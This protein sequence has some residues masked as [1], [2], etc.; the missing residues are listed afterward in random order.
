MKFGAVFVFQLLLLVNYL[1]G[2]LTFLSEYL[3]HNG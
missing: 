1:Y 3:H 2:I